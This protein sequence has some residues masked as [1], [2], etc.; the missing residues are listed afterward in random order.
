MLVLAAGAL[1]GLSL[2]FFVSP[3]IPNDLQRIGT[4][5][6]ALDR[7]EDQIK[8]AVIG[9]SITMNG[10]DTSLFPVPAYNLGTTWQQMAEVRLFFQQL[11]PSVDTVFWVIKPM[12]MELTK[13]NFLRRDQYNAY[14]MYGFRL[15]EDT[16]RELERIFPADAP[17]IFATS[18][19]DQVMQSRWVVRQAF[20]WWGRKVFGE[21]LDMERAA[22][23][24]YFPYVF[25]S[26]LPPD[27][28]Q[29][30]VDGIV[31]VMRDSQ[32]DMSSSQEAVLRDVARYAAERSIRLVAVL[33]PLNPL[34]RE[35]LGEQYQADAAAA[36]A[37]V[38][39]EEGQY[40]IDGSNTANDLG[41]FADQIHFGGDGVRQFTELLINFWRDL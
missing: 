38:M 29:W 39:H 7:N 22:N 16:R 28:M 31:S 1:L 17:P 9:D 33:P 11:P 8:V 14:W 40:F 36:L 30:A 20:E 15:Q 34:V 4:L 24:L 37:R 26:Q 2:L 41:Y 10:V 12:A 13:G 3:H 25:Q 21:D 5:L 32:F 18:W 6:R 27:R 35:R 23:D 19:L